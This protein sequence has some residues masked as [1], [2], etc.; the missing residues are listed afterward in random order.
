[1]QELHG[2]GVGKNGKLLLSFCDHWL[3]LVGEE[4][5]RK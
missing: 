1:V 2:L 4:D 5:R 3:C